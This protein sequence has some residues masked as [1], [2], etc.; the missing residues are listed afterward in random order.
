[1]SAVGQ[2]GHLHCKS[3][4]PHYPN[5]DRKSGHRSVHLYPVLKIAKG[6]KLPCSTQFVL[7]AVARECPAPRHRHP[8]GGRNAATPSAALNRLAFVLSIYAGLQ[9]GEIAALTVE[10]V[11]TADCEARREIKLGAHQTKGN[12]G[13]TIILSERVRKEIDSYMRTRAIWLKDM[14]L[15]ASQRN[16]R[17]FSTVSLSMLFNEIYEMAGIR[18]SSH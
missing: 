3:P 9:V 1:M 18:T 4:C 6:P 14:S 13:R 11:A 7:Y 2:S 12:K 5:S 17:A 8:A 15:I 10:D 16:G